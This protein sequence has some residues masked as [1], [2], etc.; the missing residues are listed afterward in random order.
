MRLAST[1]LMLLLCVAASLA[2]AQE[3]ATAVSSVLGVAAERLTDVSLREIHF[4]ALGVTVTSAKAMDRHT[5]EVFARVR[6]DVFADVLVGILPFQV[7]GPAGGPRTG[8]VIH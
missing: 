3:S 4:K 6:F 7:S 5:G 1:S 2:P 8:A